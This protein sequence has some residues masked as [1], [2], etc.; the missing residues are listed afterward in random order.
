M[1]FRF[2]IFANCLPWP[3]RPRVCDMHWGTLATISCWMIT[4]W[5]LANLSTE[6]S[7]ISADVYEWSRCPHSNIFAPMKHENTDDIGHD[8]MPSWLNYPYL[9]SARWRSRLGSRLNRKGSLSTLPSSSG[10]HTKNRVSTHAVLSSCS[11]VYRL[12]LYFFLVF[13]PSS[14]SN[15]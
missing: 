8:I 14:F 2:W 9:I 7:R 15:C 10:H 6:R 13:F 12:L 1:P 11:L 3:V 4:D 5:Y